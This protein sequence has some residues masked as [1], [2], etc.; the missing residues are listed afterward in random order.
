MEKHDSINKALHK[1]EKISRSDPFR[2]FL[3]DRDRV[4]RPR[5]LSAFLLDDRIEYFLS[6]R[7]SDETAALVSTAAN[8]SSLPGNS[9]RVHVRFRRK[10][11]RGQVYA[12]PHEQLSRIFRNNRRMHG[13]GMHGGVCARKAVYPE[14]P[15]NHDGNSEVEIGRAS[16]RERV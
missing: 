13:S 15:R 6:G 5:R 16:C 7:I 8:I 9:Q 14:K 10:F 11:S 3:L 2:N 4:N 12:R 1:K